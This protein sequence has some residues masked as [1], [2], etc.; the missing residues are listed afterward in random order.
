MPEVPPE[1]LSLAASYVGLEI[2]TLARKGKYWKGERT[3][4]ILVVTLCNI[5]R[6]PRFC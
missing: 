4:G 1:V 3:P 2:V 5:F 6:V